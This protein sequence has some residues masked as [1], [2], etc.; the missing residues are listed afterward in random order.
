VL[1]RTAAACTRAPCTRCPARHDATPFRQVAV[2]ISPPQAPAVALHPFR[3]G[4][5][6]MS[7]LLLL[8]HEIAPI[9]RRREALV[10]IAPTAIAK[11][12]LHR[13]VRPYAPTEK[14]CV[15][16]AIPP[17]AAPQPGRWRRGCRRRQADHGARPRWV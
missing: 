16:P 2:E 17:S 7:S 12:E 9:P 13:F 5:V 14:L 6:A 1:T 4:S 15:Q 11:E 8:P 3:V 10:P